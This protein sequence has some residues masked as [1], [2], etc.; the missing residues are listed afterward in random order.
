MGFTK[1]QNGFINTKTK[2]KY[3]KSPSNL[4]QSVI[5]GT[6]PS[7]NPNSH[8]SPQQSFIWGSLINHLPGPLHACL[9]VPAPGL[10]ALRAETVHWIP[11]SRTQKVLQSRE[12]WGI[13]GTRL[14]PL[15][16]LRSLLFILSE[17]LE[18]LTCD[19]WGDGKNGRGQWH[20]RKQ[21]NS[22]SSRARGGTESQVRLGFWPQPFLMAVSPPA[23]QHWE[24]QL[25]SS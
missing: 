6:I 8:K 18:D 1:P 12:I 11:R 23:T 14:D 10:K 24:F 4:G 2:K 7:S 5:L 25:G 22:P 13:K 16:S 9:T 19:V 20:Q 15:H 3:P 17:G 21:S